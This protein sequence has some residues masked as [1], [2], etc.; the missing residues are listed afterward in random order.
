MWTVAIHREAKKSI[1]KLPKQ[2]G[3][4]LTV[5]QNIVESQGPDG[6]K[7]SSGFNDESLQGVWKACRSSR[8]SSQYRVIYEVKADVVTVLVLRVTAHDYRRK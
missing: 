6:L 4:A 3:E 2:I 1:R 7:S 5:W 8:L